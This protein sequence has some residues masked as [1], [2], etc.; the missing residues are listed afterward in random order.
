MIKAVIFDLDGT[1]YDEIQ[2]VLS[3][4]REVSKHLCS[5]YNLNY[6]EVYNV[7]VSDFEHGLRRKNFDILLEKMRLKG[8]VKELVKIYRAHIPDISL[9][10]DA[11][12][13]LPKLKGKYKLG[14]I[15]EGY[16]KTQENKISVLGI[17]EYFDVIIIAYADGKAYGKLSTKPFKMALNRI[18][19][20]PEEC[21]Y[22]GNDPAKDFLG[23]NKLGIHTVRVK[24]EASAYEPTCL[25][26][27]CRVEYTIPNLSTLEVII[28]HINMKCDNLTS[29]DVKKG[30]V[31]HV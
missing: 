17:K 15:T 22:V 31:V 26:D 21:I 13:I 10:E 23:A 6:A 20:K 24:R 14:I 7:L 2:F 3:G 1:L 8:N 18:A 30:D 16:K 29:I 5:R 12:E 27:K 9:Y 19:V 11:K 4:F 28:N 25:D